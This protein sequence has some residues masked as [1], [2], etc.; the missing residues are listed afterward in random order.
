MHMTPLVRSHDPQILQLTL[1]VDFEYS[2]SL[3][4]FSFPSP[5][6]SHTEHVLWALC[7]RLEGSGEGGREG[8]RKEEEGVEGGRGREE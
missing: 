2:T 6:P 1:A 7:M 3:K 5:T 8:G 4:V